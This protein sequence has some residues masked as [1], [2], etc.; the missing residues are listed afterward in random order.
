VIVLTMCDVR[1]VKL[2]GLSLAHHEA[3]HHGKGDTKIEQLA[4]IEETELAPFNRGLTS[5]NDLRE[6]DV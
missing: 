6:G 1:R 2:E 5:M 3:S 4:I